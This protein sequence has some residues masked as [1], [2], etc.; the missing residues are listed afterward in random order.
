MS[1]LEA[2]CLPRR[3]E[4]G[5]GGGLCSVLLMDPSLHLLFGREE[6]DR[7]RLQEDHSPEVWPEA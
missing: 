2:E 6:G 3:K 1:C 4:R 5:S 7:R